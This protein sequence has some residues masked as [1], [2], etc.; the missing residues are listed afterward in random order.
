MR[1]SLLALLF[2]YCVLAASAL[3][4]A[5]KTASE[6]FQVHERIVAVRNVCAWP[7]L[8]LLPDETIIA[9]IYNHPSHGGGLGEVDCWASTDGGRTWSK[10]GTSTPREPKTTRMNVAAGLAHN[11][12]LIVLSSGWGY[13]P[14]FHNRRLPPWVC[15]SSDGGKTWKVDKS[16]SAVAF[17][18]GSDYED[19]QARMIK[20]FGD[21]VKLPGGRL[22][23]SFY[24]DYGTVWV[25]FS[26][27][28]GRTWTETAL[29]SNDHR[30]E[31]ALLR[32]RADRWLAACRTERGP[33]EKTPAVG[34]ELF[35]S[36]DEGRTWTAKGPVTERSQHPGHLLQL[37]D[38]RIL[39]SYGMRDTHGI[40]IRLSDD[41]GRT[42]NKPL[43]LVKLTPS[44][45]GY[46]ST[47]QLKDGTLVTA[48]YTNGGGYHMGVVRW[49]PKKK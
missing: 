41:E 43:V 2:G 12:D 48:Y 20:P 18:E 35:V 3:A 10:R 17:P 32:L 4:Q 9:T 14:S 36:G 44:D 19:R 37:R 33:D 15:R 45:L 46:P 1:E 16:K 27:D 47:V 34:L 39:L 31:T 40:G 5:G 28:D 7:N 21:I 23:A 49:T 25:H 6:E 11:G 38:G 42:W 30:G 24:H 26:G 29:L 13:A 22:A 8:T